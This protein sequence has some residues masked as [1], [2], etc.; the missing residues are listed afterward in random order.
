MAPCDVLGQIGQGQQKIQAKIFAIVKSM[1]CNDK[2]NLV[3]ILT[4]DADRCTQ[5]M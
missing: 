5:H 1:L 4:A 3:K 2:K